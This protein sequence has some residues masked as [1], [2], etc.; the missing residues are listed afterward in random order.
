MSTPGPSYEF[1]PDENATF[2]RLAM[3][4]RSVG[5]W[6]ELYGAILVGYFVLRALPGPRGRTI[7]A[8][9]L[10]TGLLFILLGH[11]TRRG[12]HAFRQIATTEG[13]DVGHLRNALLDLTRFYT[14]IE[15]VVLV[16]LF[17]ALLVGFGI[18]LPFA[19]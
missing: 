10:A 18:L 12:A 6:F 8:L 9:D 16:V 2:A 5:S 13:S 17:L 11:L 19:L 4:M 1:S 14:W 15:R 7:A 3:K